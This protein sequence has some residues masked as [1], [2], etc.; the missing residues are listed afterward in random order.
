ML[1]DLSYRQKT[2]ATHIMETQDLQAF[3][4]CNDKLVSSSK[5]EAYRKKYGI[6][7]EVRVRQIT[8]HC[9]KYYCITIFVISSGGGSVDT[10]LDR[11]HLHLDT[12]CK[13]AAK[14]ASLF[15]SIERGIDR[16]ICM[17]T[18][19]KKSSFSDEPRKVKV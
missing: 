17:L 8:F 18:P 1:S 19:K 2:H 13:S 15:G 9:I 14:K 5:Q 11:I 12:P 4:C 7:H 16:M 10:E 3:T 6:T